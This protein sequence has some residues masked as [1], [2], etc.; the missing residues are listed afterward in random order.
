[1]SRLVFVTRQEETVSLVP[2]REGW[3]LRRWPWN[4]ISFPLS[5]EEIRSRDRY[6]REDRKRSEEIEADRG[7]NPR[8]QLN[9]KFLLSRELLLY[10]C[11]RHPPSYLGMQLSQRANY[12]HARFKRGHWDGKSHAGAPCWLVAITFSAAADCNSSGVETLRS[13]WI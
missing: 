5:R 8:A 10:I 13:D 11:K 4:K 3:V 9:K 7:R 6:G 1:M 2:Q 12:P